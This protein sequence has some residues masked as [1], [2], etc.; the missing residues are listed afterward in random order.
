MTLRELLIGMAQQHLDH[1]VL[2]IK[3]SDVRVSVT[4]ASEEKT[5]LLTEAAQ[6][7]LTP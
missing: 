4:V 7:I 2:I 6:R 1:S 5:K 3:G